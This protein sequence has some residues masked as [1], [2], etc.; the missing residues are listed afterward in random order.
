M[1]H[2]IQLG[3]KPICLEYKDIEGD[4]DVNSLTKI[5]YSNLF[6]ETITVSSLLNRIGQ[7]KAEAEKQYEDSKLKRSIKEG[8]L[9]KRW[10]REAARNEGKFNV[11]DTEGKTELIKLTDKAITSA[12]VS[13]KGMA[14]LKSNEISAKRDL[15]YLDSLY[16]AVQDKSKKL[17]N[18][19]PKV[20]PDEFWNEIVDGE[21][22]LMMIRTKFDKPKR[23]K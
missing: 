11:S 20:I 21:I 10:R 19:L 6:G 9:E 1:R 2:I 8:D 13:D 5:D 15:A 22:N 23:K 18:L 12:I 17:D 16:W 7:W 3:G 14:T 4:I